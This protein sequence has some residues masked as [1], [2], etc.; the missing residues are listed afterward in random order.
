MWVQP[1]ESRQC[2]VTQGEV[3]W[4]PVPIWTSAAPLPVY[5]RRGTSHYSSAALHQPHSAN[6]AKY[7]PS[8]QAQQCNVR[9]LSTLHAAKRQYASFRLKT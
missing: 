7:S 3:E 9:P 4:V 8:L 1:L 6:K 5:L 2:E